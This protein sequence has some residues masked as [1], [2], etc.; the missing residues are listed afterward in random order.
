[1]ATSTSQSLAAVPL[2][3]MPTLLEHRR[4][5]ACPF[6]VPG[7]LTDAAEVLS[8]CWLFGLQPATKLHHST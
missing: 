8:L 4:Y 1:M 7:V 2:V 5:G 6:S 3:Q